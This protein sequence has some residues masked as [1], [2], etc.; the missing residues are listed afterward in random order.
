MLKGVIRMSKVA[1]VSV[2]NTNPMIFEDLA[3]S[4][5]TLA[6]YARDDMATPIQELDHLYARAPKSPPSYEEITLL[7]GQ[8]SDHRPPTRTSGL[9]FDEH[10][11][12]GHA[13]HSR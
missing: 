6:S 8:H 13:V 10:R 9:A 11:G 12:A 5:A 1:T 3:T 7:T 4:L 2:V